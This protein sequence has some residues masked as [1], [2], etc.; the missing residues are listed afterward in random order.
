MLWVQGSRGTVLAPRKPKHPQQPLGSLR[1]QQAGRSWEDTGPYPIKVP[2]WGP[3]RCLCPARMAPTQTLT[4]L[5]FLVERGQDGAWGRPGPVPPQ[6]MDRSTWV[7]KD[8]RLHLP[9]VTHEDPRGEVEGPKQPGP[10][11]CPQSS[12]GP[13]PSRGPHPGCQVLGPWVVITSDRD[14]Y[15]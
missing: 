2:G 12:P 11:G 3:P 4:A 13:V 7:S 8:L 15:C 9:L 1:G 5:A 10:Q 14:C 6:Q